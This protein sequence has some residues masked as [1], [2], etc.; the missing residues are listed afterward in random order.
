MQ[1]LVL[2]A[3]G[4]VGRHIVK[5]LIAAGEHPFAL[6]RLPHTDTRDIQW[7]AGD[8]EDAGALS[9]PPFQ[10]LYC[11]AHCHFLPGA[12]PSFARSGLRRV[13]FFT[14]TSVLTKLSSA[15]AQER[16]QVQMLAD[17]ERQAIAECGKHGIAW[18]VLRPT[19]IYDEGRDPSISRLARLIAR[20]GFFPLAGLG[21]GL[22]QPVHAEDL[23]IGALQAAASEAAINH[24]YNVPGLETVTYRE[25]IGRIFDGL[26]KPRR[27]IPMPPLLWRAAFHMARRAFPNANAEMG[28]R[29]SKDL[30]FD[31][32]SAARDFGWR[33]RPFHP[34]FD[35]TG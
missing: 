21:K 5:Q 6:S 11:T 17:S 26:G 8:L 28:A 32:S 7:F 1:S 23:A 27:I 20:F 10:T 15:D 2:G 12:L 30:V 31:G 13:V 9:F 25:M 35:R 24:I 3:T 4:L 18:T 34:R 14:S 19:I 33:P 22:R 16:K 29:M